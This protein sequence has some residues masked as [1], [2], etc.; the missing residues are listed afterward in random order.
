MGLSGFCA[1]G[2][3]PAFCCRTA[4][5]IR[6]SGERCFEINHTSRLWLPVLFNML[7]SYRRF[8][9]SLH[10]GQPSREYRSRIADPP[11]S[12][13]RCNLVAC[14]NERPHSSLCMALALRVQI[15]LTSAKGRE[16][17]NTILRYRSGYAST[18]GA[19]AMR[20]PSPT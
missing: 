18:C 4:R 15:K 1:V 10:A 20:L 14:A 6:P 2:I 8:S 9:N 12:C 11:R 16:T 19:S 13:I 7:R 5:L 3:L 17:G